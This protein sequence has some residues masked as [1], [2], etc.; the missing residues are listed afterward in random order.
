MFFQ[1]A[2]AYFGFF[3]EHLTFF[4]EFSIFF[5]DL[6]CLPQRAFH[7]IWWTSNFFQRAF[8]F[9]WVSD[10][11]ERAFCPSVSFLQSFF[12]EPCT[13]LTINKKLLIF[14]SSKIIQRFW[15]FSEHFSGFSELWPSHL[16]WVLKAARLSKRAFIFLVSF[17]PS[18]CIALFDEGSDFFSEL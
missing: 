13:L 3:G 17:M 4:T 6:F 9:Q 16:P 5:R 2:F 18:H 7:T 12:S 1:K 11:F 10:L 8:V 15:L 14:H